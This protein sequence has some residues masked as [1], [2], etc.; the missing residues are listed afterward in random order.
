MTNQLFFQGAARLN[1]KT[2]V[3][4]LVRHPHLRI[5]GILIPQPTRDLLWRP[6]LFQ[7][8]RNPPLQRPVA[9]KQARLWAPC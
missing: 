4:R 8:N 1:E 5:A 3:D 7:F 6:V 2:A 9:G